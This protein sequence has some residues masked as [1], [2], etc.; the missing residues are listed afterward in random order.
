MSNETNISIDELNK[1]REQVVNVLSCI[2][3]IAAQDKK[4]GVSSKDYWIGRIQDL[5]EAIERIDVQKMEIVK[6]MMG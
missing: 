3:V 2:A 5:G 4:A 1:K 6:R